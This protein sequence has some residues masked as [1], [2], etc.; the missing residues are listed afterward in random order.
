MVS[1]FIRS[2]AARRSRC[3]TT[4]ARA[5]WCLTNLPRRL[6]DG[7]N[8]FMTVAGVSPIL[9]CASLRS[10]RRRVA[11]KSSS[12]TKL[13]P[14]NKEDKPVQP[15]ILDNSKDAATLHISIDGGVAELNAIDVD[16]L[17]RDL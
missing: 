7:P 3:Q 12:N 15:I 8:R 10:S 1:T 6:P 9:S 14:Y 11:R 5:I 16:A 13:P 17:I 4:R 2:R